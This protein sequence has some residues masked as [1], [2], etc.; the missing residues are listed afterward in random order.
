MY[1]HIKKKRKLSKGCVHN[2]L[3]IKYSTELSNYTH[4]KIFKKIKIKIKNLIRIKPSTSPIVTWP[5][6][7]VTNQIKEVLYTVKAN[8]SHLGSNEDSDFVTFASCVPSA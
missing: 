8:Q 4:K 1:A 3:L 6:L 5:K 7:M 2:Q